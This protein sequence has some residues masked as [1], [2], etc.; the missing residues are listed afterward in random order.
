MSSAGIHSGSESKKGTV[1]LS[2]TAL[3]SSQDLDQCLA[4]RH[5]RSRF[6]DPLSDARQGCRAHCDWSLCL[7]AGMVADFGHQSISAEHLFK[8][9]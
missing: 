1:P 7:G 3:L 6:S 2:A 5:N 9:S 4:K 8:Y